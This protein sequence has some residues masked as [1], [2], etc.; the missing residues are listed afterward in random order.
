[1][2]KLKHLRFLDL[3]DTR[4]TDAGAKELMELKELNGLDLTGTEVSLT[5]LT[6][7]Q[8]PQPL[9]IYWIYGTKGTYAVWNDEE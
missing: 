3:S 1:V 9:A 8:R 6:K 4:I 7:L 5:G 2:K